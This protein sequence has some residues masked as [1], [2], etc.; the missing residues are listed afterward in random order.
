MGQMSE[1]QCREFLTEG[2][3]T[4]R[5]GTVRRDG[6]PHVTPVWFVMD[7]PDLMTVTPRDSVKGRAI[8]RDPRVSVCVDD[9][10]PPFSFVLMDAE[11]STTEDP[12][13]TLYWST[14]NAERYVGPEQADH[15]GRLNAGEGTLL[16]RIS[17]TKILSEDNVTEV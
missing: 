6:R 14:R 8:L 12:E 11:V 15:Y 7:G 4:A 3:R 5:L 2:T 10:R 1:R 17:P 16:L 13:Q 9:D